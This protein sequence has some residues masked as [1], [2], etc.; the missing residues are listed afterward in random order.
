MKAKYIIQNGNE[1]KSFESESL[2][3]EKCFQIQR[4][5]KAGK[6]WKGYYLKRLTFDISKGLKFIHIAQ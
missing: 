2:A 3:A 4:I 6:K 1:S 5:S